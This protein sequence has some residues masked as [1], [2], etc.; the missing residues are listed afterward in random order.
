MLHIQFTDFNHNSLFVLTLRKTTPQYVQVARLFYGT[1]DS[2]PITFIIM[3]ALPDKLRLRQQQHLTFEQPSRPTY[4]AVI[5]T[6]TVDT[7]L[8]TDV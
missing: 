2:W 8:L 5:A 1:H 3:E 7:Q 4:I 6:E